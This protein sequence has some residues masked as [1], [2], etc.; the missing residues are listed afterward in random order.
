MLKPVF[1]LERVRGANQASQSCWYFE[2]TMEN[3]GVVGCEQGSFKGDACF[4]YLKE[5]IARVLNELKEGKTFLFKL[6]N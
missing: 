5:S 4:R 3:F 1:L 6:T 2:W